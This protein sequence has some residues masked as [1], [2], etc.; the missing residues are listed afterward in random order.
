M[1]TPKQSLAGSE[2]CPRR[3]PFEW[4]SK[5]MCRPC[6]NRASMSCK[7]PREET[8]KR[9]ARNQVP[10]RTISLRAGGGGGKS[11]REIG[12]IRNALFVGRNRQKE[13]MMNIFLTEPGPATQTRRIG[14]GNC[15]HHGLHQ[16]Q[17]ENRSEISV[18]L[19]DDMLL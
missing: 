8:G 16:P 1:L 19:P 9:K 3:S 7:V 18:H 5:H 11:E 2:S 6:S 14:L 17:S 4:V 10:S 15:R 12:A 13:D